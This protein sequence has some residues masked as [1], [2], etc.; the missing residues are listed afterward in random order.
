MPC[1]R[2]G[3]AESLTLTFPQ[4]NV[5]IVALVTTVLVAI[6][7]MTSADLAIKAQYFI[8]ARSPIPLFPVVRPSN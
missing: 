8:M 4:L 6:I 2:L 3:F 7:A 1:I 5:K